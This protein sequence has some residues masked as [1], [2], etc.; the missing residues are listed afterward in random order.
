MSPR[1]VAAFLTLISIAMLAI[2]G[3][4]TAGSYS[5]GISASAGDLAFD[6]FPQV[7]YGPSLPPGGASLSN[8]S[9]LDVA[10]EFQSDVS[11][12]AGVNVGHHVIG[13]S[14]WPTIELHLDAKATYTDQG[15]GNLYTV[16]AGASV[17][18]SD[19]LSVNVLPLDLIGVTGLT[20]LGGVEVVGSNL[21]DASVIGQYGATKFAYTDIGVYSN[22][23]GSSAESVGGKMSYRLSSGSAGGSLPPAFTLAPPL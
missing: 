23:Y 4:A 16:G 1:R 2:G 3:R 9:S 7:S 18:Y 17:S 14:I 21:G 13:L 5:V 15:A 22:I 11:A 8:S 6:N 19:Q 12:S 20:L 10:D